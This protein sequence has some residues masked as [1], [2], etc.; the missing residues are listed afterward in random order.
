MLPL[1]ITEH[2]STREMMAVMRPEFTLPSRRTLGRDLDTCME[3][4]RSNLITTLYGIKIVATT[5][6]SWTAHNR[7]ES[8]YFFLTLSLMISF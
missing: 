5:A 8:K 2:P 1:S 4:V 7:S 6:D 3:R